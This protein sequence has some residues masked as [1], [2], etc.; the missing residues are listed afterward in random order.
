MR[1]RRTNSFTT[2]ALPNQ[3][4]QH[5]PLISRT[6]PTPH[7]PHLPPTIMQSSAR[8]PTQ[9]T[10]TAHPET[11]IKVLESTKHSSQKTKPQLTAIVQPQVKP[12]EDTESEMNKSKMGNAIRDRLKTMVGFVSDNRRCD[13]C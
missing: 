9:P 10:R 12:L 3:L 13:I 1:V 11:Y 6:A 5:M 4:P 8:R 2:T 7:V